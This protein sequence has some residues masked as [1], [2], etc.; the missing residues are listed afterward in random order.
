MIHTI[1]ASPIGDILITGDG[2][3]V[4]GLYTAEHVRPPA[5]LGARNDQ[6]FTAARSQLGEYF[7]GER[8]RFD[9]ELDQTGTPFQRRV[10]D[11]LCRIGYGE[12]ASYGQI[13][14]RIGAP[15]AMR[16]V[17]M[18]NGR[19]QISIVIPCHRVVGSDGKLTGYAGGLTAK[20]WLLDHEAARSGVECVLGGF[21]AL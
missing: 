9:L 10:W 6:A 14:A 7:A 4:A 2:E 8:S 20:R 17:G 18:A 11:E 3:R 15:T 12:V 19:N 21:Q 1:L 5:Q 13:A 16:A